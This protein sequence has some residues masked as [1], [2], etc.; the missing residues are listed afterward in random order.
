MIGP[1]LGFLIGLLTILVVGLAGR[2]RDAALQLI[3]AHRE[4]T[5]DRTNGARGRLFRI[6]RREED[7]AQVYPNEVPPARRGNPSVSEIDDYFVLLYAIEA[8]ATAVDVACQRCGPDWWQRAAQLVRGVLPKKRA[9][10]LK[11]HVG[12]IMETVTNWRETAVLSEQL[13]DS[14]AYQHLREH[15]EALHRYGLLESALVPPE[16]ATDPP[17]PPSS[18]THDPRPTTQDPRPGSPVGTPAGDLNRRH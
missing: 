14:R 18:T 7:P 10:Y 11:W 2:R 8:V 6:T 1:L 15:C 5:S 9:H 12:A 3:G 17:N 13:D 16:R 4:L